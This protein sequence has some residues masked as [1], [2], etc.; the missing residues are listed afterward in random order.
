[1]SSP[2]FNYLPVYGQ[3]TALAISGMMMICVFCVGRAI[4][5]VFAGII[6]REKLDFLVV[7]FHQEY[8]VT[9]LVVMHFY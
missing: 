3:I 5:G 4:I 7:S 9:G 1:M 6:G 2:C 8:P